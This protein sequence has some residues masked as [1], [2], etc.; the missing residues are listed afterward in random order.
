[1]NCF[2]IT[3][4]LFLILLYMFA[5]KKLI[6]TLK[7]PNP[8]IFKLH[9]IRGWSQIL[10]FYISY[11]FLST[12]VIHQYKKRWKQVKQMSNQWCLTCFYLFLYWCI[13][14]V[15]KIGMRCKTLKFDFSFWYGEVWKFQDLVISECLSF[16]IANMYNKIRNRM[17]M[18]EK[19][20]HSMKI[21]NFSCHIENKIVTFSQPIVKNSHLRRGLIGS[22][23]SNQ[24]CLTC[25]HLLLSWCNTLVL[26]KLVW[27]VK[28]NFRVSHLIPIFLGLMCYTKIIKDENK[29]SIIDLTL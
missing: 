5:I 28:S 4:I 21:F 13:T 19:T 16:L 24:W 17:A 7:W 26:K 15:L 2:S 12:D 10:E 18:M 20:V 25:F 22:T 1:M 8:E 6:N 11:Q 9:H 29:L 27:D 14:S 3:A 23:M